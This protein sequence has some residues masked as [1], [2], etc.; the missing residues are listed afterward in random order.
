MVA[1]KINLGGQEIISTW[2]LKEETNI[3]KKGK[4]MGITIIKIRMKKNKLNQKGLFMLPAPK[5]QILRAAS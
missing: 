4:S 2:V 5:A 3:Q 1:L